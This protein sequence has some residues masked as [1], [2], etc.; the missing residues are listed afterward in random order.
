M[1]QLN[2]PSLHNPIAHLSKKFGIAAAVT[3]FTGNIILV[4]ALSSALDGTFS[5]HH[6]GNLEMF[7]G[8]V[9]FIGWGLAIT[10]VVL[11]H[12]GFSRSNKLG[13]V[14]R[15]ESITGFCLGYS[16]PLINLLFT[17]IVTVVLSNFAYYYG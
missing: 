14:G 7:L 9:N 6:F 2:N 12:I 8:F 16:Y 3:G 1:S 11:G 4:A 10:A 17:I 15:N 13:R 5:L